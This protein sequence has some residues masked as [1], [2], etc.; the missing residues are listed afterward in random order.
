M[1]N[2]HRPT[3]KRIK[4]E[5]KD[6]SS[7]DET[8]LKSIACGVQDQRHSDNVVQR[9][10]DA[11]GNYHGEQIVPQGGSAGDGMG[12][13][14][15]A[16]DVLAKC[17][18]TL[19]DYRVER[20]KQSQSFDKAFE[21]VQV[22]MESIANSQG[23]LL[24]NILASCTSHG[25]Q[26]IEREIGSSM[27]LINKA[28]HLQAKL[29]EEEKKA[30]TLELSHT[31]MV[32]INENLELQNVQLLEELKNLK[33]ELRDNT[34]ANRQ[35]STAKPKTM[36]DAAIRD[37]WEQLT[38]SIQE[39][40]HTLSEVHDSEQAPKH[41]TRRLSDISDGYKA[42]LTSEFDRGLLLEAYIWRR[43]S[44]G[45]FE[46]VSKIKGGEASHQFKAARV[47]LAGKFLILFYSSSTVVLI[48]ELG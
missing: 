29:D 44:G 48:P 9:S 33:E 37:K 40:A 21:N 17:I 36:S 11:V 46:G 19:D 22:T 8:S 15:N 14:P 26:S 6:D 41:M 42:L 27:G 16:S 25:N 32:Q 28:A 2:R 20:E 47:C 30:H 34:Q 31:Q 1:E 39:L 43:I 4:L 35:K 13:T 7:T 5:I 18:K 3:Q 10:R 38:C 12:S 23:S 45:I 24:T